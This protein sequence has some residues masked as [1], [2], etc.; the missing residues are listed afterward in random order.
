MLANRKLFSGVILA[1]I[2]LPACIVF[3]A[4]SDDKDLERVLRKLDGAAANFRSTSAD[5]EFDSVE[6][7]PVPDKDVQKG[8]V[9]YERK[10]GAFKMAAHIR[11]VN[12][13]L[14]PKSTPTRTGT[15]SYT[16]S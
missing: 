13:K 16:K 6:T 3:A 5:F 14:V 2:L 11:E 7:D 9:Y 8:T 10:D 1:L 15:S 4:P 12:R